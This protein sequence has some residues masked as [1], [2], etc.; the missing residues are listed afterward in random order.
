[1]IVVHR[2]PAI[3]LELNLILVG[4]P[5]W[6]LCQV[7]DQSLLETMQRLATPDDA[8]IPSLSACK[9]PDLTLVSGIRHV[10]VADSRPLLFA[11]S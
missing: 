4:D 8:A 6:C 9:T 10:F 2:A 3:F 7:V 11:V 1:M 5:G